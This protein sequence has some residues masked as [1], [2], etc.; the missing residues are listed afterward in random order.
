MG[1]VAFL[2]NKSSNLCGIVY[3]IFMTRTTLDTA[4]DLACRFSLPPNSLGYCGQNSAPEK[5]KNYVVEGVS[6]VDRQEIQQ[7]LEKFIVLNPYLETLATITGKS[8][9]S[10]QVIE[11]YWLGNDELKKA[12][13]AH[14]FTLLDNFANQGVPPWFVD[15]LKAKPPKKFIPHHLFQVLHVGVGRASGA[16]PFNLAS[17]NNC[18]IRWGKVTRIMDDKLEADLSSLDGKIGDESV[19]DAGVSGLNLV[20]KTGQAMFLQDFLP[21]LKL[22]DTVAVHWGQAV[23][24]LSPKEVI[25]LDFWTREVLDSLV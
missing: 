21:K 24:I 11:A 18:M 9:F 6:V 20:Q 17:I 10:R 13:P 23:K 15:E 14:Y 2:K 8:K 4:L 25:Q 19:N 7:E 16:V 12:K 22:G 5:F 3:S 1:I